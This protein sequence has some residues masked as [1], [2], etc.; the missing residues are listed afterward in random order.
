MPDVSPLLL[1]TILPIAVVTIIGIVIVTMLVR[2]M[3]S[4][5][6]ALLASGET[7]QAT[8]LKMW[9]TG[10]SVNDNPRIGLLLEVRSAT[11]P[12]YQVEVKQV[13][14]RLQTS[15][16]QPGMMLEVKID[17]N[18]PKKVAISGAIGAASATGA[19]MMG[20][21]PAA[22]QQ[23]Q[24]TLLKQDA[25]NRELLA[26]GTSAPAKV[27]QL[28]PSGIMVNGNNPYATLTLEVQPGN[29]PPFMA[30]AQGVIAE[31]SVAKFQPGA[32][33]TVKYDPNDITKVV[34]EHS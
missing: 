27:L 17:P 19:P 8:V 18:D 13:V 20:A 26:R 14:S 31:Q 16:F 24:E 21:S 25:F 23:M 9:D 12:A 34:I 1:S 22:T 3:A 28:A 7:A 33:I 32:L 10:M 29:R 4:P 6:R 15:L 11:R 2:R 30:Q 5:N